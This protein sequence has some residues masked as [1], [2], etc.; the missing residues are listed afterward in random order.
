[1]T[2]DSKTG[3]REGL[4]RVA[5]N[6]KMAPSGL[7]MEFPLP[8]GRTTEFI[9]PSEKLFVLAHLG[10][11]Q[12]ESDSW[13]FDLVGLFGSPRSL[14]YA[15][16]AQFT[17]KTVRSFHQCA[18]NPLEPNKPMR[19]IAN[20]EWRGVLLRDILEQAQ[21]APSCRY[22]WAYGLDYG[23]FKA[24]SYS[25][26][27]QEHYVKDLPV[28]Y[29]MNH[30]VIIATHLNGEPL[31][32][33][34]GFPARIIAPGYYGTNSVKWLCRVEAADRRANAYFTQELYNDRIPGSDTRKPVWEIEPESIIVSP[35]TGS[36]LSPADVLISGWAWSA[37]EVESVEVSTDGGVTWADAEVEPRE[38][39]CWQRFGYQWV[40][41]HTGHY[42]LLSRATDRNGRTQPLD[43]ARNSV[44]RVGITV[45]T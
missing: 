29:V 15:D 28:D 23:A 4:R 18:G 24:P 7:V 39:A 2:D 14:R 12:I 34:H 33:K 3:E 20:V 40:V 5:P 38:N 32:P 1:M 6:P 26:P 31:S 11:P 27:L 21:I 10:V 43:G 35:G 45:V 42:E 19:I 44:H 17:P 13:S 16:L 36:E 8:I 37:T 41:N 22:I 25:S 30:D 9:T